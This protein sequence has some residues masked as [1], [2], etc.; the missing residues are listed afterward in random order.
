MI[1]KKTTTESDT[2]S[3]HCGSCQKLHRQSLYKSLCFCQK[4]ILNENHDLAI[5]RS[6]SSRVDP[7][8]RVAFKCLNI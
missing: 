6:S 5:A 1:L 7:G 4:I 8:L 3:L 2:K